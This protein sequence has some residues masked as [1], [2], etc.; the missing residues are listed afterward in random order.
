MMDVVGSNVGGEPTQESGQDIVRAAVQCGGVKIPVLVV[1]PPRMLKLMLHT[2]NSHTPAD[3]AISVIG[4]CT[5][6]AP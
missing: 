5:G 1:R 6:E 2:W 3:A 4:K